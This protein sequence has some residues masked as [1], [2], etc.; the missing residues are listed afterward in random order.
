MNLNTVHKNDILVSVVVPVYNAEDYLKETLSDIQKQTL[1]NFEV[2]CINDGSEDRSEEIICKFVKKDGRFRYFSQE[3]QNAGVARN[4]GLR[5]ARGTYVIFWDA[6]DRFEA[7]ALEKLYRQAKKQKADICVCGATRFD[8][9]GKLGETD[10]YLRTEML[11]L[12]DP[13]NKFDIPKYLYNFSTNVPWNKLYRREFLLE[14]GIRFQSIQQANDVYF[15]MAAL[16][17]A[18]RIT[19]VDERLILYRVYNK[20]SLT[21]QASETNLCGYHAFCYTWKELKKKK[22]FEQIKR[23][24]QNRVLESLFYNLNI[25]TEYQAY[26]EVYELIR[27]EGLALFGLDTCGENDIYTAWQYRDLE[28]LRTMSPEEFLHVKAFERRIDNEK[29]RQNANKLRNLLHKERTAGISYKLWR[30]GDALYRH[31][32]KKIIDS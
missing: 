23:S 30:T 26:K 21:G 16:Y 15:T 2:V 24:C 19:F 20:N 8:E 11:P 18:E 27:T 31:T 32:L 1:N 9:D 29:I 6:D 17:E 13:F 14:A 10:S 7:D 3:H 4:M 12:K 5:Y 22:Y 28:R 25:Q